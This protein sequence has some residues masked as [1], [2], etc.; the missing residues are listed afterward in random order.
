L[1]E[2]V[3]RLWDRVDV[4]ESADVAHGEGPADVPSG[5]RAGFQF[6]HLSRHLG[7]CDPV[8]QVLVDP[9]LTSSPR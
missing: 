9:R 4:R 2:F 3:R 7:V 1:D 5:D 8:E 6:E